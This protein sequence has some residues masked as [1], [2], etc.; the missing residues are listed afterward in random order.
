MKVTGRK[1]MGNI[2]L[3]IGKDGKQTIH[4]TGRMAD[5]IARGM[6]HDLG[7]EKVPAPETENK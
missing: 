4:A 3:S 6:A 7:I 5:L 2:T 1:G